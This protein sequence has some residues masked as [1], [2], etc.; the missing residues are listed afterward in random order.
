M[1]IAI[2]QL[3]QESNTF[4][5]CATTRATFEQLGVVRGADLVEQF[6]GTNELG[7]FIQAL[8]SW[9]EKPE[10]V[11]LA[12]FGAWPSGAATRDTFDWIRQEFV[13]ALQE[14]LPVDGV[15]LALHGAMVADQHP[16]VEGEILQALRGV[17]GPRV[18]LVATLDLHANVTSAMVQAADALVLY[19]AMPHVDIVETG[20]RAAR[21][22]R[23][24]VVEGAR[25]VTAFQKLPLIVPPQLTNTESPASPSYALKQQLLE[26][27]ANPKLLT[28]G[29]AM[30]QP[31]LDIPDMGGATLVVADGD[32]AT[33]AQECGR[34]AG[35]L[36]D[37]RRTLLPTLTPV[38]DAVKEA[39]ELTKEA[40]K[41]PVVLSDGSD[42][43]TAGAPGDSNWVLRELV[44]YDWPRP[45]LVTLV[46]P[47]VVVAAQQRGAGAELVT[48]LGG[49]LDHRFSKPM[50]L[51]VR[52][53]RLFDARF[54]LSG[55]LGT[56]LPVDMGPS[57]V[58]THRQVQIIV[59][60]HTGPHFA[61]EL[62][63]TAGFDP[64]AASVL[65]AKSPCGFRAVYE[66]RARKVVM[67]D[68]PGCAPA[69]FWNY[70]YEKIGRPL[71]PWDELPS[72][73]PAPVTLAPRQ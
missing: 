58:L 42:A 11:G 30:V 14:A 10:I 60:S 8:R 36:W 40:Y 6:A 61:P 16:D 4:N 19:H 24:I 1:R 72:W 26:L 39:F 22:L 35:G 46:A 65:V 3:W 45:A 37:A 9:P 25:P 50:E 32:S 28:A 47:D 69:D 17:L 51:V 29:L 21:L 71:W 68:A 23:R 49:K 18:P 48:S 7:G 5:P 34:L 66:A 57:A 52:V 62:F 12:R 2:G 70:P 55:H 31:W 38:A 43:T 64:F 44:R 56:N 67:V 20:Q 33:A 73:A 41:G 63:R 13:A 53:N 59:T 27:E 15:L 54:V